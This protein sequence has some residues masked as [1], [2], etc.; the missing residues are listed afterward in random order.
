MHGQ[1][2][3]QLPLVFI[4]PSANF[5]QTLSFLY[6]RSQSLRD[7]FRCFFIS[8]LDTRH[9]KKLTAIRAGVLLAGIVET[10]L[11][12]G[13]AIGALVQDSSTFDFV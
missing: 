11:Q 2:A 12:R 1:G 8:F 3:K 10:I 6:H 4:S 7:L 9:N 5:L 13:L